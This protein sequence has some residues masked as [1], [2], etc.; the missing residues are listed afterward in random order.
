MAV[1]TH[2]GGRHCGRV[3]FQITT[4][5]SRATECNCSICSKKGYLHHLV[6]RAAGSQR[7]CYDRSTRRCRRRSVF[8]IC[9]SCSSHSSR[10]CSN[11]GPSAYG[12]SAA[13]LRPM[14]SSR[15]LMTSS[16]V[17]FFMR[18]NLAHQQAWLKGQRTPLALDSI[19]RNQRAERFCPRPLGECALVQRVPQ[20]HPVGT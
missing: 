19:S 13:A 9:L 3:R 14:V 8:V 11:D 18:R 15:R 17:R 1:Q 2:N 7:A 20:A 6:V 4:D 16:G 5:F 12:S 10:T